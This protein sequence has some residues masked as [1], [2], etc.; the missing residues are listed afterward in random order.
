MAKTDTKLYQQ[1]QDQKVEEY[2]TMYGTD[3]E[4]EPIISSAEYKQWLKNSSNREEADKV[5]KL[6]EFNESLDI[7]RFRVGWSD[8]TGSYIRK[9]TGLKEGNPYYKDRENYDPND[10]NGIFINP[11]L[12]D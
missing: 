11:D 9:I 8:R 3:P 2:R 5:L 4:R 1:L 7:P 12:A 10:I 6:I